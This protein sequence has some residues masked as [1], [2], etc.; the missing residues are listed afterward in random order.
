MDFLLRRLAYPVFECTS[1]PAAERT[2]PT[3]SAF[4]EPSL[5][6]FVTHSADAVAV[7]RELAFIASVHLRINRHRF[8]LVP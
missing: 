7:G 5:Q 6:L 8:Y 3:L 4:A 2:V 1:I